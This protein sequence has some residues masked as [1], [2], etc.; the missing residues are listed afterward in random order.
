METWKV[1]AL[2]LLAAFGIVA[3]CV[4]ALV[5]LQQTFGWR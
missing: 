4:V 1:W 5:A 3:V 2:L